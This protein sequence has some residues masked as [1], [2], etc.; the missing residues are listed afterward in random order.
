M[1]NN[2]EPLIEHIV[3]KKYIE[4]N[5]TYRNRNIYPDPAYFKVNIRNSGQKIGALNALDSYSKGESIIS[6]QGN[7]ASFSGESM[8]GVPQAPV[9]NGIDQPD[10]YYNGLFLRKSGGGG[11]VEDSFI[12]GWDNGT[13]TFRMETTFNERN[14]DA[15][16]N[17]AEIIDPSTNQEIFI[18]GNLSNFQQTYV[19]QYLYDFNINEYR[20]IID[21]DPI[22][23]TIKLATAFGPTWAIDDY[24]EIVSEKAITIDT[25]V[26]IGGVNATLAASASSIDDF[27]K[28]TFIKFTN[29]ADPSIDY[30]TF[31]VTSY[32]GTSKQ[33]TFTP[34]VLTG[35][36]ANVRYQILNF[37]RDIGS[38]L[39]YGNIFKNERAFYRLI[40]D[41]L[42]LPNKE[43]DSPEGKTT[44]FYPYVYVVFS[45]DSIGT[46]T[47]F[48]SNNPNSQR[49]VFKCP[50]TDIPDIELST[51]IKIRS[52]MTNVLRFNPNEDLIFEVYLPD[53][54]LFKTIESDTTPPER[55]KGGIQISC[56][57]S[58]EKIRY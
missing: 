48:N 5:S 8:G 44:A 18:P 33:I 19:G 16:T 14:W 21:Y 10:D 28:G 11:P 15:V 47:L 29:V 54:R 7:Q 20:E 37:T 32:D 35:G 56:T 55:P 50:I 57:V 45:N 25:T 46:N 17:Q 49:A 39:N 1:S 13:K 6:F 43:I 23:K 58:F 2:L 31:T 51:F 27:Y 53:G 34:R 12:V 22:S 38:Y 41:N 26:A 52:T 4:L 24:Y 30:G 9:V 42:I 40:L 3:P 36:I